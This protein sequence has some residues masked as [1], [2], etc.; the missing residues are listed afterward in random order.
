[1]R[2]RFLIASMIYPVASTV[3]LGIGVTALLSIPSLSD[4]F[5]TFIWFVV[6]SG[7][8]LA[9]PLCWLLA[10]RLTPHNWNG[11]KLG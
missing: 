6:A 10:P 3:M 2:T 1:M 8:L 9:V 4:R 7:F 5:S 11:D